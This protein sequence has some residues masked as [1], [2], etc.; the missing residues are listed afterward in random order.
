MGPIPKFL[1][2]CQFKIRQGLANRLRAMS[3]PGLAC[4]AVR[5]FLYRHDP[6]ASSVL[7]ALL[8]GGKHPR[9][10]GE[11]HIMF[12]STRQGS[13]EPAGTC[14]LGERVAEVVS[15]IDTCEA[16]GHAVTVADSQ[17]VPEA[18]QRHFARVVQA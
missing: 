14:H 15:M 18:M 16:A 10:V 12:G 17:L 7:E 5:N 11:L 6:M 4:T 2:T 8:S 3:A 1:S 9:W 13:A